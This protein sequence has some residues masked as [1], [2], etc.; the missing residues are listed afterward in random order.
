MYAFPPLPLIHRVLVK[1]KED[2]KVILVAPVCL[3]QHSFGMLLDLSAATPFPLSL[4][5]DLLSQNHGNLL[6]S[7][8]ALHLTAWL[9][10]DERARSARVQHVLLGSRK[11]S[12]RETYLAKV[13]K[14]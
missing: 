2:A 7:N 14:V 9:S 13:K 8:L 4:Q 12:T 6:H 10:A 3:R 1:V 5:P 11:P